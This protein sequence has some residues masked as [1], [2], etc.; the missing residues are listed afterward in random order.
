MTKLVAAAKQWGGFAHDYWEV[1]GRGHGEPPGGHRAIGED[2]DKV[3]DPIPNACI[4]A[5]GVGVEAAVLLA[6]WEDPR[7]LALVVADLDRA[8]DSITIT[9]DKPTDGLYVLLDGRVL[10][11]TKE[12]LV[13]VNGVEVSRRKPAMDLGTLW[14]TSDH[15]D[16][17]LQFVAR[18]PAFAQKGGCSGGSI[19]VAR[20][21]FCHFAAS[22]DYSSAWPPE[23][24]R[25]VVVGSARVLLRAGWGPAAACPRTTCAT[26]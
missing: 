16:P 10:D 25:C 8:S 7:P 13:T 23:D 19:A 14:M 22:A 1:D 17:K 15:P 3:R 6:V 9:C 12:V 11:L 18:V 26:S 4:M 5:A 21:A 2:C 20:R 24:S